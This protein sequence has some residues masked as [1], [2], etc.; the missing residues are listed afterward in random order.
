M[1]A[2]LIDGATGIMFFGCPLVR[3]CLH[4]SMPGDILRPSA[5]DFEL[6]VFCSTVCSV[7]VVCSTQ[8]TEIVQVTSLARILWM[9]VIINA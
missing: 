3:V 7:L 5:I 2:H 8:G 4:T 9:F 6:F 1:C